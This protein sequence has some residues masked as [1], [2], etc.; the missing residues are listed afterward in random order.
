MSDFQSSLPIRTE[1][2]GDV[3]VKVGDA[4]LPSQ[5]LA[6]DSSGRVISKIQDSSG[7]SL[8]STSNSLNVNVT[9]TVPVSGT[10]TANIGTTNGLA[11][12]TSVNSLLKPASTLA[13][14]TSITNTVVIKADTAVNQTNALKVDGSAVTQP[15][16]AVSLPLPTGAATSANQTTANSSL[17]SIDGKTPALGQA[18]AASSVPVVLTASQLTTLT[19]LSSVSVNN[20]SGASAVNIQDGGNSI[21]VDSTN[22]DIRNLTTARDIVRI[23]N[24]ANVVAVNTDGTINVRVS[25]ASPGTAVSDFNTVAAVAGGATSTHT[26]TASADFFLTQI[27]ASGSG[28][29]RILVQANAVTKIVQFNSTANPNMDISFDQPIPILSGQTITIARLNREN[30]AQD[31][32]STIIGYN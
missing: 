32:Y 1:N 8:S 27:H 12:D 11:L 13:A 2:N 23:G 31:V 17:S 3:V 16:S 9:N 4:T 24:G 5:Q 29:M 19:P 21:T 28:K 18:L 10:V 26:Y 30:N 25:D 6:I 7:N 14:V 15:V 20:A 22:L